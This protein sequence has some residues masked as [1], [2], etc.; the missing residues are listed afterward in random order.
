M[1]GLQ[2]LMPKYILRARKQQQRLVV[3]SLE[4][5]GSTATC[6]GIKKEPRSSYSPC[7]PILALSLA[8]KS[9]P[10]QFRMV[11]LLKLTMQ[12]YRILKLYLGLLRSNQVLCLLLQVIDKHRYVVAG[13][14]IW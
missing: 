6:R 11:C 12:A 4:K 5:S 7:Q 2:M 14:W 8:L 10:F 9:N 3:E 1:R 13:I